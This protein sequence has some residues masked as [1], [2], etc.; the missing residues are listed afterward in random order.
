MEDKRIKTIEQLK[1]ESKDGL[2]CFILLD[3]GLRSSKSLSSFLSTGGFTSS[4]VTSASSSTSLAPVGSSIFSSSKRTPTSLPPS[5]PPTRKSL[6]PITPPTKRGFVLFGGKPVEIATKKQGYNVQAK[7]KAGKWRNLNKK[8]LSR[9]NALSRGSRAADNTVSA[10]FRVRKTNKKVS[11]TASD[12][13]WNLNQ[14]KFRNYKIRKGKRIITPN[15][16]VERRSHRIDSVGEKSGLKLAR[17]VKQQQ[18]FRPNKKRQGG[19]SPWL[20]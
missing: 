16:F 13:Y 1:A 10:Q 6:I 2:D 4:L 20:V 3:G 8:P 19:K 11:P 17:Y 12:S 7:S 9:G 14:H 15:N 18:W 5:S